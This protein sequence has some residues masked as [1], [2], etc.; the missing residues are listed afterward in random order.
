M[1]KKI[2]FTVAT[3]AIFMS[4]AIA[5]PVCPDV[6]VIKSRAAD[7]NAGA[8]AQDGSY[9]VYQMDEYSTNNT[10]VFGI[11]GIKAG[12]VDEAVKKGKKALPTL[13]GSPTSVYVQQVKVC[14]CLYDISG[15]YHALSYTDGNNVPSF[16]LQKFNSIPMG[17]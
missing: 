7:M 1:L 13:S 12:S 17:G 10:W 9:V 4:Q 15:G 2:I 16:N 11:A 6:G 3:S 5:G 8:R 14:A